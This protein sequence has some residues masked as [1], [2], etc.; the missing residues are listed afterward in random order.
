MSPEHLSP[1]RPIARA[2]LMAGAALLLVACAS[3]PRPT[4]PPAGEVY[5][6]PWGAVPVESWDKASQDA[7]QASLAASMRARVAQIRAQDPQ[8]KIPYRVLT[9]SGG[10]SRGAFGAGLLIGLTEIGERPRFDVVT[11]ISTGALMATH[12][13]LGPE[14]DEDLRLYTRI[15]NDDV[16]VERGPLAALS[17]DALLDT[18]PLREVLAGYITERTLAAVAAEQAKGRRLFIG[19][20]NLDANTFTVWDMG[21]IATSN[22]PDKLQRYRDI[23]LASASFP[24]AFPPVYIEVERDGAAYTQMHVDG[25]MRETVFFYD[26]LEEYRDAR[27]SIGLTREQVHAELYLL[28]NGTVYNTAQYRPVEGKALAI[29]GASINSLM[30]KVTLSSLYR[31]WVL[32]LSNGADFHFAYIPPDVELSD[33]A[34]NFDREEMNRLFDY[35]YRRA[36]A[37]E[38]WH[39]QRAPETR[40]ELARLID[41]RN[42]IDKLEARPWLRGDVE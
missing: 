40:E 7:F 16:F 12:A 2:S 29:A 42:S 15:D 1:A 24:I 19:T 36:L 27:E 18:A 23:V 35:G 37:G 17:K 31:L 30:R 32:A 25:G 6:L 5:A 13:F 39:T 41:P 21:A 14:Y 22:R 34:L 20:T 26:F 9:L 3:T 33:N 28:N 8:A 4:P 10:G 11:G 38:A